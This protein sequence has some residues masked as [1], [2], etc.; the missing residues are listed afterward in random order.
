MNRILSARSRQAR[1]WAALAP[2]VLWAAY[3]AAPAKLDRPNP[4]SYL[5]HV[6]YL[7]SEE[8]QG[9]GAGAAGLRLAEEYV[10]GQFKAAGLQPAGDNGSYSQAFTVTT[11]ATMGNENKFEITQG[12][13]TERLTP[14]QD[15][16]PLN[17]S[18]S[19]SVNSGVVFAGYGVSADEQ[20][21]DDYFHLPVEGKIVIVLRYEPPSFS[22]ERSGGREKHY[23]H[24]AHMVSKA[25]N[26]R[27]RGAKAVILINGETDKEEELVKFGSVAGPDDAAILMVQVAN[28]VAEKWFAATGKSLG[29]LQKA[30]NENSRPQSFLFP[31]SFKISLDVEIERKQATI[32]NVLGYLPGETGEYVI[33]GA[34]HDHLGLGDQSSLA[35]SQI[36]EVHHGADDNASG[37]AGVVELARLFRQRGEKPHRGILFMTFGG[38]EI[39]LLGSAYWVNHPTLP[40]ENATA[41]LNMDMIGRMRD[42]KVYVGGVG[43]G[44]TFK[45]L[46]EQAQKRHGLEVDY[47]K[48]THSSSDHTSF[49]SKQIPV[50]FFFSGLHS[51]YHK[52]SDTWDKISAEPAVQLLSMVGDIASELAGAEEPPLFSKVE[53]P[54]HGSGG[55]GAGGGGYGPYFGSVPDFGQ[56]E[57]GVKFADVRADSPADKAGLKAGDILTRFG[58]KPINNLYDFTYALRDSKVGEVVEVRVLRGGQEITSKVTLEQRR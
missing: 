55:D 20:N 13:E 16:I 53:A 8:L 44:S 58:D 30:I 48:E 54:R 28:S 11:G 25:I 43:T 50:L 12:S 1:T 7:A 3:A 52:P 15:Y 17:F 42:S 57:S 19:G 18:S 21:Y 49:A 27:N 2:F 23:S 22:K 34:H 24:H 37:T 26:A 29:E 5:E 6:K 9:R 31:D 35:P 45:P 41:M 46:I 10:A 39:G 47:S 36:G 51:D 33:V 14:E 4:Q 32:H 40:I 56:V 38:E